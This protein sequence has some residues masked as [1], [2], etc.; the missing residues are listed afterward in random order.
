PAG[1]PGP[2][3]LRGACSPPAGQLFADDVAIARRATFGGCRMCR[4]RDRRADATVAVSAIARAAGHTIAAVAVAAVSVAAA[5]AARGAV[6][7]FHGAAIGHPLFPRVARARPCPRLPGDGSAR[8]SGTTAG[9]TAG[10]GLRSA[11][12]GAAGTATGL[13]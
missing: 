4:G 8:S 7:V 9:A 12:D 11:A 3:D 13:E 10:P 6:Q 1:V 2:F 5:T